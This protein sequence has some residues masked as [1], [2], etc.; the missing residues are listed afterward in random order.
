MSTIYE[1]GSAV[2]PELSCS[3]ALSGMVQCGE[4]PSA[5][6]L[7][8]SYSGWRSYYPY[9]LDRAGNFGFTTAEYAVSTGVCTPTTPGLKL[10]FEFEGTGR[11]SVHGSPVGGAWPQYASSEYTPGKV[12]QALALADWRS[13]NFS[14][15]LSDVNF[16]SAMTFAAWVRADG[17]TG[18]AGVIAS[19]EDQFRI[20]RFADGTI[21]WAFNN[22]NP[23]YTWVNTEAV[24]PQGTWTHVAVTYDS[25]VVKT[26]LNGRL[27][28]THQGTGEIQTRTGLPFWGPWLSLGN[29]HDPAHNSA[30]IGAID[31]V[32]FLDVVWDGPTIDASFFAGAQGMCRLTPTVTLAAFSTTAHGSSS[33]QARAQLRVASTQVGLPG[34]AVRL[35]SYVS[36][37]GEPVGTATLTTDADGWVT[38]DAPMSPAAPVNTYSSG[39]RV[40]F[41]G[42][43]EHGGSTAFGEVTVQTATPAVTWPT[44]LPITYGTPLS[45]TQLNASASIPGV[46]WYSQLT[47]TVLEPGSHTLSVTFESGRLELP[48][49]HG[50]GDARRLDRD[51]VARL[52]SAG[53]L[54]VRH[55]ARR[56][57]AQRNRECGGQL[58]V[59]AP[60]AGTVLSA[61]ASQTLTATFTPADAMH[62][63]SASITTTIDVLKAPSA[64]AWNQPSPI[65]YGT[66]L[67][68]SIFAATSSVAGTFTYLPDAG[69][70]LNAG[71]GQT[72]TATFVPDD[73]ANYNGGS[74]STTIDVAKAAP[75]VIIA[76]GSYIYDGTP[77][78]ANAAATGVFGEELTPLAFT[79]N[80]SSSEPVNAGTYE[81]VATFAGNDNYLTASATATIAIAKAP[82]GLNWPS[83]G[84]I[85]YG[86]AARR[87]SPQC[88]G[89]RAWQLQLFAVSRDR[90]Q[91]R[92]AQTLTATF[93]PADPVNYDGGLVTTT[94]GV[95]KATP[96]VSVT[97]GSLTYDGTPHAASG[98]ATGVGGET[99]GP[100]TIAYN[101]STGSP[102]NAG[103]YLVAASYAGSANYESVSATTSLTIGKAQATINWTAPAPIVYG[104]PL[105]A[106][107]LNASASVAGGF[108][109]APAAGIVLNA[110]NGHALSV[111]FTPAD[112]ANYTGAS[113]STTI[114]VQRAPLAVRAN[115]AVKSFGAPVPAFV[116]SAAGFVNGDSFASLGGA[117]AFAT[118][119]GQAS[120][121]GTYPIVPSGV[122]SANY[123][124]T[125]V[126]GTLSV[127]RGPTS[128]SLAASPSPS[129]N[130][131]PM[132]FTATVAAVAPAAG[133]P[134]GTVRFFDG[135]TLVGSAQLSAGQASLTTAG[136][137]PGIRTIEARYDGDGSFEPSAESVS[138]LVQNASGTPAISISSSRN[139]SNVGQSVTLTAN[140]NL[141]ERFDRRDD[142]V[143]RRRDADRIGGDCCGPCD[144]DDDR[145]R[146]RLTRDHGT[147][148]RPRRRSA[149]ALPSSCR[150]LPRPGGRTAPLR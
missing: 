146:R 81:A 45:T 128:V 89:Q 114:D 111:V 117:I 143:L 147:S 87:V 56:I 108:S 110:G 18:E 97:G 149:G 134:T 105:S 21:R 79:Y 54:R 19:R 51:A 26:Y 62:Y 3:D 99:L 72:L 17:Q 53:R 12:G 90:A 29:R 48:Q 96:L 32:Q 123:A 115:D 92:C 46:F 131:E 37:G 118:T 47:G 78:A 2:I 59:Y 135:T 10:W 129:G 88:H 42:D 22:E 109:Y 148:Y 142:P 1:L 24:V 71:S 130:N 27:V 52:E 44:P 8:T 39:F 68:P 35:V 85:V 98:S 84:A 100:L 5:A 126:I 116:A 7:D 137:D 107:Q 144:V 145:A 60:A 138:H 83:P 33:Y 9:A 103:N 57:A 101:G 104:T 13:F 36:P 30:L 106:A 121:V 43:L 93:T 28:H 119:A 38:W 102:V 14:H 6:P 50:V 140:V 150:Q 132:T 120:P 25:G 133:Q 82:V 95:A 91:R 73:T 55:G 113:A 80:G 112:A 74:V 141:G 64:L 86:S 69:T 66:R 127:V 77:H 40:F 136:L 125:F 41:D 124:I 11:D 76:G 67:S 4:V 61:G 20:A 15:Q 23:G 139:P 34:K 31:E 63:G 94:I 70:L 122:T 49:R 58:V 16:T 75:G 65:V